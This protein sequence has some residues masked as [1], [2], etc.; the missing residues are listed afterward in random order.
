MGI[1]GQRFGRLAA[2]VALLIAQAG[3]ASAAYYAALEYTRERP[4][5]RPPAAKDPLSPQVPIIEHPDVKRAV[6][7]P[8]GADYRPARDQLPGIL[9]L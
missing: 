7:Q 4:Q 5:G 2:V 1:L 8:P 9:A 3:I 6:A